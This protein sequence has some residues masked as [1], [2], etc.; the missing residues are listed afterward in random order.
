MCTAAERAADLA[1]LRASHL[2]TIAAKARPD[3][4]GD[5]AELRVF[6]SSREEPRFALVGSQL[7]SRQQP[8]VSLM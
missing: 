4:R 6:W 5:G 3:L 2:A 1:R 7:V 8:L